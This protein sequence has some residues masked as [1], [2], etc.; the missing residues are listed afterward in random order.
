MNFCGNSIKCQRQ[1][2]QIERSNSNIYGS[3]GVL[4]EGGVSLTICSS[5]VWGLFERGAIRGFT[6][7]SSLVHNVCILVIKL[8]PIILLIS[9]ARQKA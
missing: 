3:S 6:V 7:L 2:R 8:N 9:A 1:P 4:F 5:R